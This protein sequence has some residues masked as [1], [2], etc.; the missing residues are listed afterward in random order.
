M[1]TT[2]KRRAITIDDQTATTGSA[3]MHADFLNFF[4]NGGHDLRM[5]IVQQ[6]E[7]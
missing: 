1:A 5:G 6:I 2:A 7:L 3:C 4:V